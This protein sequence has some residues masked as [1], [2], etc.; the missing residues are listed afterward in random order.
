MYTYIYIQSLC[1]YSYCNRYSYCNI[2]IYICYWRLIVLNLCIYIYMR[3][4]IDHSDWKFRMTIRVPMN[5]SSRA[6]VFPAHYANLTLSQSGVRVSRLSTAVHILCMLLLQCYWHP[7]VSFAFSFGH[8]S[9]NSR[10]VQRA[11]GYYGRRE[12]QS[13]DSYYTTLFKLSS[14]LPMKRGN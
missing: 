14:L 3:V 9:Q 6:L 13:L 5:V 10:V 2:Y 4:D 11:T 12:T 1:I 8:T 7:H